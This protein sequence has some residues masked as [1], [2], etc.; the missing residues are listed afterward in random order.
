MIPTLAKPLVLADG[1]G[2]VLNVFGVRVEVLLT[3][4]ET[5]G[6][7]SAYQVITQPGQGPVVHLHSRDDEA[8]Y[9]I[10]GEFE[11]LI[12]DE[13]KTVREGGFVFLPRRL[14]H[15]FRNI[16]DGEGRLMGIATPAGHDEFFADVD[17]LGERAFTDMNA[18]LEVCRKHG[19]EIVPPKSDA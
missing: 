8:F 7:Y 13:T 6:A 18:A 9:V 19:I 17:A 2:R 16:G 3:G 5:G 10:R 15:A 1:E 11:V 14:P 4:Q 12:G